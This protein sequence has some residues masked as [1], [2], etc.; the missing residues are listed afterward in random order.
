MC[1]VCCTW[2]C[3]QLPDGLLHDMQRILL[4][5]MLLWSEFA[6]NPVSGNWNQKIIVQASVHL[7][8]SFFFDE[9][10]FGTIYMFIAK[11]FC[12]S[13]LI[14]LCTLYLF[15]SKT[16][17]FPVSGWWMLKS[18]KLHIHLFF[19]LCSSMWRLGW[20]PM[21]LSPSWTALHPYTPNT[22]LRCRSHTEM[23][24]VFPPSTESNPRVTLGSSLSLL[25]TGRN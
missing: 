16:V 6:L 10:E 13:S 22:Q 9:Q 1:S 4:S 8:V 3:T 21:P 11:I 25:I 12:I 7:K 18:E 17:Q 14:S 23:N 2:Q 15:S 24:Q 19:L 20:R 5:V